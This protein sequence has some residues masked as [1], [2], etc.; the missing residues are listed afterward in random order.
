M[1]LHNAKN[2]VYFAVD[3]QQG[4]TKDENPI[5]EQKLQQILETVY[6]SNSMET[7]IK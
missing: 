1:S 4:K 7:Y 5:S 2:F 6:V 3:Q